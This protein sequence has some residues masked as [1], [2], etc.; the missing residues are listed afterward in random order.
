MNNP[1]TSRHTWTCRACRKSILPGD[2]IVF[3]RGRLFR[4]YHPGTCWDRRARHFRS[5]H[6]VMLEVLGLK[7][8]GKR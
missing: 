5:P 7:P 6:A 3:A 4:P 8:E 2:P 1:Q